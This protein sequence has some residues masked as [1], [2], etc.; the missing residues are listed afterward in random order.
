[1]NE[2]EYKNYC[3]AKYEEEFAKKV[4]EQHNRL[5]KI[6][7]YLK[8]QFEL[9]HVEWHDKNNF[10]GIGANSHF[11]LNGKKLYFYSLYDTGI[12]LEYREFLGVNPIT[13]HISS[14]SDIYKFVFKD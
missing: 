14:P 4:E 1:M 3:K 13:H 9:E 2:L 12:T 10:G 11:I 7:F 5:C 8:K 6:N